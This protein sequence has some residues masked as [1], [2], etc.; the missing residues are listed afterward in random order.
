MNNVEIKIPNPAWGSDLTTVILDLEK[1]RT[2]QLYSQVPAYIFF[3][4]K[5]IFHILETLGSVR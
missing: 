5:E 2:K 3:Q 1:L 4:L